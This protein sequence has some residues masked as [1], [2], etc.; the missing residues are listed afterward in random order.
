MDAF[1]GMVM[2]C[3]VGTVF[4]PNKCQCEADVNNLLLKTRPPGNVRS[5]QEQSLIIVM[6]E[7]YSHLKYKHPNIQL[8][9]ES[10]RFK[11]VAIVKCNSDLLKAHFL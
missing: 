4:N 10:T 7:I 3:P 5:T 9:Q 1:G 11:T 8:S 2:P 6:P